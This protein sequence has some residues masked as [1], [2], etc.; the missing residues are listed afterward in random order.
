[1][2]EIKG[3][4]LLYYSLLFLLF[5]CHLS[6]I[7]GSHQQHSKTWDE[8]DKQSNIS[9]RN[10]LTWCHSE[11][12]SMSLILSEYLSQRAIAIIKKYIHYSRKLLVLK[13]YP[14][15]MPVSFC[16]PSFLHWFTKRDRFTWCGGS[17]FRRCTILSIMHIFYICP[18][19]GRRTQRHISA[20][21]FHP[22]YCYETL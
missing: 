21:I 13:R 12:G 18:N 2:G 8:E 16:L 1:M 17:M 19:L 3:R 6:H 14:I 4:I 22:N 5:W 10:I 15:L 20:S 9:R 11:M 7:P